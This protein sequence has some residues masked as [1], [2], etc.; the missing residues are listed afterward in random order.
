MLLLLVFAAAPPPPLRA[1]P[2]PGLAARCI[3]PA[4]MSG[5]I[6]SLDV[7]ESDPRILYVAAAAGGVWKSTDG[8]DSFSC[9]FPG[10]PNPSMGAVAV[11]PSDPDTVYVGTGEAN[12]RNS[13]SAGNGVFV[14]RDAGK[15]WTHAGLEAARHIG[16]IAVHP[17][18]ART[19]FV[20]ALG[21]GWGPNPERGLYRTRDAGK[22][23][24]HVLKLDADTGCVDVVIDPL[25]PK[26]VHAAAYRVRRGE[27]M[28]G[29]PA[30]QFGK[31][32]GI[33]R[34]TDGG[35]TFKRTTK[36]L[37]A[38]EMGRI[39]LAVHR[40]DPRIMLAVVQTE[41][42]ERIRLAGQPSTAE[43]ARPGPTDTGGVFRSE[44]RGASWSKVNDLCP[45]PFYFG[46]V[47]IDPSD[48][49]R[50]W[51][52]G[53]PLYASRDGGRTFRVAQA[54]D[55]HVDHHAL[56]IDPKD[57]ARMLLGNDGGLYRSRDGGRSWT[58]LRGLP[59]SQFYAIVLDRREPYRIVGGLQD[60]GSWTGPSRSSN[61]AGILEGEW[62]R[63]L[64]MDGFQC[65]VPDDDTAYCQGQ[66]GQPFRIDLRTGSLT[67]IR[68]RPP[69]G[70][71]E[72][73][74]NWSS[75]L[76]LSPHDG[77]TLY[78]AGDTVFRSGDRGGTWRPISPDLTR[79]VPRLPSR[80]AGHTLTAL[81]E[82]PVKAG[83]LWAGSDDG[84]VHVRRGTEWEDVGKAILKTGHV[85]RVEPSP[86]D[87]GTAWLAVDRHRQDDDRPHVFRT[88]D[89]GRTWERAARG[90]P[91]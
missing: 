81:S 33:Y 27:Y 88:R 90:L 28:G 54:R 61:P 44:D 67:R 13:V 46:K 75:P 52:L 32:A 58:H 34:S 60:N 41:A 39:G 74:F 77:R 86:F 15:T 3:G 66:Y 70:E 85:T 17:T 48:D 73:R 37:P 82:S 71:A 23:W 4:V 19:A 72:Y 2:T 20:A 49:Q 21:R 16:R 63:L 59:I 83:L 55:V 43:N 8:G 11:A 10:R 80:T 65:A 62:R 57:S 1:V 18:D 24:E 31:L 56:W 9:V 89:H 50:V 42:T 30:T 26:Y 51:V 69:R 22:T 76:L 91:A 40:K 35:T 78:Y 87:E 38:K 68:P 25:D 45:R 36:G 53:I 12:M 84:R 14:S 29:N 7:V 5:R 79:G 6:P 64:A 47:R